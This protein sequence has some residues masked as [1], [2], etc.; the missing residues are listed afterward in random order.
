MLSRFPTRKIHWLS[1]G[2]LVLGPGLLL[3]AGCAN[4]FGFAPAPE[5]VPVL[6][7]AA[8]VLIAAAEGEVGGGTIPA[9]GSPYGSYLAGLLAGRQHD[10]SI[11]A[12]FMLD[13]LAYDPENEQLLNR[14]FMLVSGDGRHDKAVELA[15]RLTAAD[16]DHGLAVLTLSVD[17]VG[18]GAYQEAEALLSQLPNKGISAI[19]TPLLVGWLRVAAGDIDGAVER[20]EPLTKKSGFGIFHKLHIALMYDIAGRAEAARAAYEEAIDLAGQP[21]LR[22]VWLAGNFFERNGDKARAEALYRGLLE[23]NPNSSVMDAVHR[24]AQTGKRPEAV[25]RGVPD[26]FAETMFNLGSL[27]S[28]ERA[29]EVALIYTHLALRLNPDLIVARIL[30]GEILQSQ[31][32]GAQA[33][34]VYRAVPGDSP[35]NWLARLRIA[36]ELGRLERIDEASAELETIAALRPQRFE[37]LLRLGNLLR[38]KERFEEA[39]DAYDRA[40]AR[41]ETPERRH[42]TLYYFRGIV[43]ERLE[44]W[45]DA[46][47]DFLFALDLEPEQPFVMNY[48]AYSWIEK[49]LHLDKAKGMLAR[50]VELR[51]DDGYIVDSLGWVYYR[52]GEYAKGVSFLERAVELR[53]QDPVIND[54]LGDAYW[55]VGRRQEARFQ[56]RRA[57]SLG[58]EVDLAPE[59]ESKIDSGL[60]KSPEDI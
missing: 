25:V 22:L 27:L 55:R 52:L 41:I 20:T 1:R 57:L 9:V 38:G 30:L 14:A 16:S 58:P 12:D 10:L 6:T 21:T 43:L 50:A 26:G 59:I 29:E 17:A 51:P 49:K 35:F 40:M 8:P 46:E 24:K 44:R 15:R 34:A 2:P 56:W 48:L 45:S 36:E 11:A 39:A 19:T 3:L 53:P 47:K 54:H 28:Q 31:Q 23:N 4:L 7:S 42:W 5:P 18:R 33:I 32:R 13:A 60:N 37:P